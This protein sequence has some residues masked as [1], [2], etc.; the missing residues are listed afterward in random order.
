MPPA[1]HGDE[2]LLDHRLLPEDHV[3][4]R[5]LGGGDL[6]ARRL[7]LAHDHIFELFQPIAGYRHDLSSLS[8]IR[9][10]RR[11]TSNASPS[12]SNLTK[13]R[14]T[15]GPRAYAPV[16]HFPPESS[17]LGEI[18]VFFTGCDPVSAQVCHHRPR[19]P[20]APIGRESLNS[21]SF[22]P[23]ALAGQGIS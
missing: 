8:S 5:G 14:A 1:Q 20:A 3:A 12:P 9:D 2:R 4:D 16:Q 10:L 6:R 23:S 15:F 13:K 18:T 11:L 22:L 21:L 19:T 17:H 7:R